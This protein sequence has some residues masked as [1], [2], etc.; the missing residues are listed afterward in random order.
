MG[1]FYGHLENFTVIW[2][3]LWAFGNVVVI[4]IFYRFWYIVPKKSGNPG[5]NRHTSVH[6]IFHTPYFK[7]GLQVFKNQIETL[8][9]VTYCHLF[10]MF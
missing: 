7:I 2:Y 8:K 10:K 5:L 3:I 9:I 4:G 1:I 6:K